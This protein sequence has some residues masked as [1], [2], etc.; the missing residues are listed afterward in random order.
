M[1]WY[2]YPGPIGA[3]LCALCVV[4]EVGARVAGLD[5]AG[6]LVEVVAGIGMAVILTMPWRAE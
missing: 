1:K 3:A 5:G 6:L 4:A 2:Q